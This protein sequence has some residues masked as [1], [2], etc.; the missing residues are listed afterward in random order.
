MISKVPSSETR[1]I[2]LGVPQGSLLG[3]LLFCVNMNGIRDHLNT[4]VFHLLHADDL[5]VYVQVPPESIHEGIK[6]LST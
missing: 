2:N 4:D 1:N 3:P 5:Q 6:T